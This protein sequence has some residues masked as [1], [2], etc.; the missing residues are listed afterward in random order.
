MKWTL[1]FI[2]W[3]AV[4]VPVYAQYS[5]KKVSEELVVS[6]APFK[7]CHASS[8]VE[9]SPGELL[10]TFFGGSG[11]GLNDV[12]VWLAK[13]ENNKWN[14][15]F[16]IASGFINDSV[17]F[18][19]WNPVL[20]KA[21]D[22]NLFLFYKVGPNPA[23]WWGMVLTSG[24]N[25]KSWSAP[26]KLPGGILGPIKNKPV[27]LADGTILSPSSK[28]ENNQW[29]VYIE[30]SSDL[31]KTW[32]IIPVDSNS[33]FK[34]I[35]PS[36]LIYP[37]QRLQILCRSDQDNIVQSWS[38]D[39]G[40]NW[41]ALSKINLPNPNSGIDAVTLKNGWKLLVYN[42][43]V[44]GKDWFNNRGKLSVA[45]SKDGIHWKEVAI[46]ENGDNEEFSYPAVIQTEDGQVHITYTYDR[47][48][49]KH[50][51]LAEKNR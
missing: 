6:N 11:E 16:S 42:P 10:V 51:V 41:G 44:R 34:V 43:T 14:A 4:F 28:E 36:I 26:E 8:L 20:F 46:L 7:E 32:E 29:K 47:K 5:W 23:N 35:Q 3:I 27:Q 1:T 18:P 22:G 33:T 38:G 40:K 9:V 17:R 24:D 2:F 15:P 48:N 37:G 31:G 39:N 50:V 45:V 21:R 13:K 12:T 19:C 49:I 30:R 25:G